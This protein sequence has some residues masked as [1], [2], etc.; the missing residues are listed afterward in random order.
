MT[1]M[2]KLTDLVIALKCFEYTPDDNIIISIHDTHRKIHTEF[3]HAELYVIIGHI[4]L[5]MDQ[6]AP[7]LH[8]SRKDVLEL[9]TKEYLNGGDDLDEQADQG[10]DRG[11]TGTPAGDR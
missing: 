1:L 5:L 6:I 9:I 4:C 10:D 2:E 8:M 7:Q 11:N 3:A